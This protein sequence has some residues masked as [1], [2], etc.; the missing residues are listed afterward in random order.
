LRIDSS[1]IFFM[2]LY[3]IGDIQGCGAA[4]ARLL[5]L[6]DFS[7]SRDRLYL[8]GDLVNRGPDSAA[9]LRRCM[10]LQGSVRALLGNHDLHLLATAHGVR[11]PSRR[12]TLQGILQAPDR[13][14]LL[15]WLRQQ[16]LARRER[17]GG[18]DLLMVHAGVL[19]QWGADDVLAHADEVH[20]VLRGPDLPDFLRQM[21]GNTPDGWS[22]ELA[23][24]DRLRVIVNALTR[25]RFCTPEG[26]MDFASSE[27]ASQAPAGLLPWFDVPGRRTSGT[28]VAFGHWSTLGWLDRP[29]LLGLDTGCVW[30]GALS[31]V[32]FGATLAERE[33]LQVDCPQAQQP[34]GCG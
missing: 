21:Y 15:D 12:D 17:H 14:A 13:Q 28:L 10:A 8:L 22:G 19:P 23:G 1:G 20:A 30:G 32:R 18:Q 27:S 6:I 29:D 2:A 9:V 31:A 33:H 25:L 26:R 5:D 11:A 34:G 16:P 24:A 4:F 3:C 7:P